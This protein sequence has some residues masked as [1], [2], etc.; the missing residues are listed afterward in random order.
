M[1]DPPNQSLNGS[2]PWLLATDE[3]NSQSDT[4]DALGHLRYVDALEELITTS[5]SGQSIALFGGYGTGKTWITNKLSGRLNANH[6]SEIGY[7]EYDAWRFADDEIRRD[8]LVHLKSEMGKNDRAYIEKLPKIDESTFKVEFAKAEEENQRIT[9]KAIWSAAIDSAKLGLP[10]ILLAVVASGIVGLI[11]SEFSVRSFAIIGLAT[12]VAWATQNSRKG[13]DIGRL[14]LR[15]VRETHRPPVSYPEEFLKIFKKIVCARKAK[16]LLILV[17]NIDRCNPDV[18]L[19]VLSTIK[20]FL[21]PGDPG[22]FFLISCNVDSLKRHIAAE[23][24]NHGLEPRQSEEDASEYIGK[25]FNSAITINEF[26]QRELTDLVKKDLSRI[27][28]GDA[29]K[30]PGELEGVA[31]IVVSAKRNSPRELKVLLNEISSAFLVLGHSEVEEGSTL[32]PLDLAKLCSLRDKAPSLWKA[33]LADPMALIRIESRKDQID[34]T[35]KDLISEALAD[36]EQRRVIR[37][38]RW[39]KV[40]TAKVRMFLGLRLPPQAN[41]IVGYDEFQSAIEDGDATT[42]ISIARESDQKGQNNLLELTTLRASVGN[43]VQTG[44]AENPTLVGL[45]LLANFDFA[46]SDQDAFLGVVKDEHI[47]SSIPRLEIP[48][49]ANL[50]LNTEE[51][52]QSDVIRMALFEW[53]LKDDQTPPDEL[54]SAVN[55]VIPISSAGEVNLLQTIIDNSLRANIDFE[56]RLRGVSTE[57]IGRLMSGISMSRIVDEVTFPGDADAPPKY[58]SDLER[59]EA[60]SQLLDEG[61]ISTVV[62]RAEVYVSMREHPE[63]PIQTRDVQTIIDVVSFANRAL[64]QRIDAFGSSLNYWL[65]QQNRESYELLAEN[66]PELEPL[67]AGNSRSKLVQLARTLL[68]PG[69][70]M[71]EGDGRNLAV[72]ACRNFTSESALE[73]LPEVLS[74]MRSDQHI[75]LTELA[76]TLSRNSKDWKGLNSISLERS[77]SDLSAFARLTDQLG[78]PNDG[79][80]LS[81]VFNG[82]V[83]GLTGFLDDVGT[84]VIA[85][86][87]LIQLSTLWSEDESELIL[88]KTL[89]QI[90]NNDNSIAEQSAL[91]I[92]KAGQRFK[93]PS[94]VIAREQVVRLLLDGRTPSEFPQT[95]FDLQIDSLDSVEPGLLQEVRIMIRA[96]L[97][98]LVDNPERFFTLATKLVQTNP[99]RHSSDLL[100]PSVN[101]A[102]GIEND[103]WRERAVQ[104]IDILKPV[105]SDMENIRDL[106]ENLDA[107]K[108]LS[109]SVRIF[110]DEP[111]RKDEPTT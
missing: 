76:L 43:A 5:P 20:N 14:T 73:L 91:L 66:S 19:R 64:G 58:E 28:L 65:D 47:Q 23:F 109:G 41:G 100:E 56:R 111:P 15:T 82:C 88:Q 86:Q 6:K 94:L 107:Q 70:V 89:P 83:A 96:K 39:H 27:R 74:K 3:S 25:F 53:F 42:A 48:D 36:D 45:A 79:E 103:A 71:P 4:E 99:R 80:E 26:D 2:K 44:W 11:L 24:R 72:R 110:L 18:A 85:A 9:L 1:E 51:S 49:I 90:A 98:H 10:L 17:D 81:N 104:F 108:N 8:F 16:K 33:I 55:Q 102:F 46:L 67:L 35:A 34:P 60:Y 40:T 37:A 13:F 77:T 105:Y 97:P 50:C 52:G 38:I 61:D 29:C 69:D 95:M 75:R 92:S 78:L 7:V 101:Y 63:D 32:T 93:T 62:E 22:V 12:G 31:R 59:L 54:V 21:E 106:L 57:N 30:E 68:D 87:Q 84:F